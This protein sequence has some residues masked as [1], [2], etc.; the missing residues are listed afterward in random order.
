MIG[1]DLLSISLDLSMSDITIS[2]ASPWIITVTGKLS[3]HAE[4]PGLG[5]WQ[6]ES[7]I[8]SN[9]SI[10]GFDDPLY[11][12]HG[13]AHPIKKSVVVD[14]SQDTRAAVTQHYLDTT[15]RSY[16]AAPSF[17]G[18]YYG[19][20]SPSPFGIESIIRPAKF[21]LSQDFVSYADYIYFTCG[22]GDPSCRGCDKVYMV[23]PNRIPF[24]TEPVYLDEEHILSYSIYESEPA[25]PV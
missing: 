17:L 18:R 2:Q 8:A 13:L 23:Y 11:S 4:S 7:I 22:I 6:K 9:I 21:G 14:W 19:S 24:V 25:C 16:P 12:A 3:Y 10:E 1:E 15:Y 5:L 20:T